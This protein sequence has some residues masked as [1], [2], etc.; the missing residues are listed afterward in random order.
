M[1]VAALAL[2]AGIFLYRSEN[3][4]ETVFRLFAFQ[5]VFQTEVD[6]FFYGIGVFVGAGGADDAIDVAVFIAD[7]D[8]FFFFFNGFQVDCGDQ[9]VGHDLGVES[10]VLKV[11]D[12]GSFHVLSRLLKRRHGARRRDE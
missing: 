3:C 4:L 8:Q 7:R 9:Q 6:Q 10:A 2:F 5:F 1:C 11:S 12:G